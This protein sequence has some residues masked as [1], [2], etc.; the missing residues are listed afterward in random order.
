M[1]WL[2]F[3]KFGESVDVKFSHV[4][5]HNVARIM[6]FL[7]LEQFLPRTRSASGVYVI[8]AYVIEA[9]VHLYIYNRKTIY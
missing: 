4:I 1:T 2:Y 9:G 6:S 3:S 8:G 7:Y 5:V